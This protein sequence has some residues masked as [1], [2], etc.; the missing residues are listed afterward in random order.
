MFI[1]ASPMNVVYKYTHHLKLI[2][3]MLLF[4][5]AN[6]SKIS[7]YGSNKTLDRDQ[8]FLATETIITHKNESVSELYYKINTKGLL[9]KKTSM[10]PQFTTKVAIK[11]KMTYF[12]DNK[13]IIVDTNTAFVN[14]VDELQREKLLLGKLPFN[15]EKNGKYELDITLIDLNNANNKNWKLNFE[16]K[17]KNDVYYFFLATAKDSVPIFNATLKPSIEY[18]L[19]NNHPEQLPVRVEHYFNSKQLPPPIFAEDAD[20]DISISLDSFFVLKGNRINT[21][22][23]KE[24]VYKFY[25]GE[26]VSNTYKRSILFNKHFPKVGDYKTM[27][28]AMRFLLNREEFKKLSESPDQQK[29]FEN[30]WISFAGDKQKAEYAI[31]S[32]YQRIEQANKEFT[33]NIEGWK[34]DRGLVRVIFGEPDRI[35]HL[36]NRE[37]W[38]YYVGGNYNQVGFEFYKEDNSTDYQL[39]RSQVFKDLWYYAIDTW[40]SGNPFLRN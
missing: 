21:K 5:C 16:R 14:D 38:I 23:E 4:S 18:V 39:N 25:M 32:Y 3:L 24:G 28:H 2:L 7:K 8:K 17:E 12:S 34:T 26:E 27:I 31:K 20:S 11:C 36:Y 33:T 15:T 6:S 13:W 22:F 40:R 30:Q 35:N 1:K 29:A 19:I 9:Y 37:I 10:D